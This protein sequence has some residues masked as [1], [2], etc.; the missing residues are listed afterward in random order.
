[1]CGYQGCGKSTLSNLISSKFHNYKI[2]NLDI[3][4]SKSKSLKLL[5]DYLNKGFSII[6]DN[7]NSNINNRTIYINQIKQFNN[8]INIKCI[9]F[10]MNIHLSKHLN[11]FRYISNQCPILIPDI[12]Y[13]MFNKN[14][15]NPDF[16]EN[17][18]EIININPFC[19][20]NLKQNKYM[21]MLFSVYYPKSFNVI[22]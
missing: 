6:L 2:I 7:T 11:H 21:N 17:I 1:M 19:Y 14:Y 20:N 10:L 22:E 15:S 8:N 9:K 18:D 16:N 3:I 5:N 13:T 12:A 4:K